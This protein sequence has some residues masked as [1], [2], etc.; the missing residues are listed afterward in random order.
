MKSP[1]NP[2]KSQ[3]VQSAGIRI[4]EVASLSEAVA[5]QGIVKC[6]SWALRNSE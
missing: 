4:D 1:L 3:G 5:Q 2:I 6:F